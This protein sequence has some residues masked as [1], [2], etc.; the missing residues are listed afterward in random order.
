MA[1]TRKAA[2]AAKGLEVSFST[3]S[4]ICTT[5][6]KKILKALPKMAKGA[7]GEEV[8]AAFQKHLAETETQVERLDQV[9]ELIGEAAKGKTCPAIDRIIEEVAEILTEYKGA[10]ACD[11]GLVG[12]AQAVEHYEIARYG[13]MITWAEQLGHSD[14]AELLKATLA[15]EEATRRGAQRS[16]RGGREPAGC[17]CGCLSDHLFRAG[18]QLG[19][20]LCF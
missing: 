11:A 16:W 6:E 18:R 13:I 10:P 2:Q 5:R 7:S 17:F 14:A 3:G 15:E 4:R 9:F 19:G 1:S 12:A 8:K 20:L